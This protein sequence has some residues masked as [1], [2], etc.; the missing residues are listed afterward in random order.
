MKLLPAKK[1]KVVVLFTGGLGDTLLF[2][3][4]LKELKRKQ[5]SITCLFYAEYENDC[6]FDDG[7]FDKKVFIRNKVQLFLY[8]LSHVK[9]FVNIYINHFGTGKLLGSVS[10]MISK[11]RTAA[12]KERR[13]ISEFTDAEQ[14]CYLVFS[15]NNARIRNI[16]SFYFDHPKKTGSY[17]IDRPYYVVQVT[18]GNNQTPYRNWPLQNWI[19]VLQKLAG[20]Y[21]D[22][23]FVI[24]G[25]KFEKE[26]K[27]KLTDALPSNCEV[28]IGDT[29]IQDLFNIVSNCDGYIGQDSGIM[30]LAVTL[31]KKTLSIFG[32]SN[33]SL[34]NYHVLDP[35]NHQVIRKE[36]YCRPCASWKNANTNRVTHPSQ[37]PDWA[38]ITTID[39]EQLYEAIVLHF[40][41]PYHKQPKNGTQE[42]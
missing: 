21:P 18:S 20:S 24:P 31:Q 11:K 5:F 39:P 42:K 16:S 14:N 38:C 8:G 4:L 22:I 15:Q 37:C 26:Y 12:G 3:P 27:Q 29:S 32:P 36:I 25:D 1:R 34:Y 33:E 28:L 41:L 23:L 35:A 6:L 30:H 40:N 10:R 9:R 17:S 19:G 13:V 2:I 7:L